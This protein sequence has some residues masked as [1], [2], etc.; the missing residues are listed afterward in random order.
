MSYRLQER[1]KQVV[2]ATRQRPVIPPGHSIRRVRGDQIQAGDHYLFDNGHSFP[3]AKVERQTSKSTGGANTSWFQITL[4][5]EDGQ[6]FPGGP[7]APHSKHNVIRKREVTAAATRYIPG[8]GHIP[9][10]PDSAREHLTKMLDATHNQIRL[11]LERSRQPKNPANSG[12]DARVQGY[13]SEQDAQHLNNLHMT[14]HSI[15]QE[16]KAL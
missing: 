15:E 14:R 6:T 1:L 5:D 16:L 10:D 13:V 3:V 12:A 8:L 9:T 11:H 4:A 2:G 7:A